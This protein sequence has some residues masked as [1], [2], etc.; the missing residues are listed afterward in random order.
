MTLSPCSGIFA[1]VAALTWMSRAFQVVERC[2]HVLKL[3][4]HQ[5]T[6]Q[7]Y[8]GESLPPDI[9]RNP[10]LRYTARFDQASCRTWKTSFP[11][12]PVWRTSMAM[13]SIKPGGPRSWHL[14]EHSMR[15]KTNESRTLVTLLLISK[16]FLQQS[17]FFLKY[18]HSPES[19][20]S[21]PQQSP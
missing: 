5:L 4:M 3:E 9:L 16:L 20:L 12:S 7:L 18:W 21:T 8:C 17:V 2:L 11:S 14:F 6:F 1:K 19:F 13:T 15:L 10:R